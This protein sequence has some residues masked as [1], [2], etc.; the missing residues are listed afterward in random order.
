[1]PLVSVV[2]SVYNDGHYV[3]DAIESI[4][5]Q[6]FADFELLIVDDGCTDD[7][8]AIIATYHDA[9]IR[10]IINE[11]NI[12]L[13]PSLNR[14]IRLSGAKY[15][16]RQDADD[17]SLPDRLS[18]EVDYLENHPEVALLGSA[19]MVISHD[20]QPRG[21]WPALAE[22]LDL[23]WSLLFV[24]P[25]IHSSVMVRRSV[26]E[27]AGYYTE[28]P[29]IARAFVEDYELWSR[30]NRIA[31]SANLPQPLLKFRQNPTS[32]SV[33]T[34]VDHLRQRDRIAQENLCWVW[35]VPE[36]EEATWRRLGRFLRHP[37]GENLDLDRTEVRPTLSLLESLHAAFCK[38]Y[39]IPPKLADLHRRRTY[40]QWTRHAWALALRQNGRRDLG[41]RLA[42]LA[43][44]TKLLGSAGL[45]CAA[46]S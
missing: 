41:C 18:R 15:I 16:A 35:G 25:F 12:G 34:H 42:L 46:T 1:M 28:R 45:R 43:T 36:L 5:A 9:R 20:G 13:A 14:A 30:I 40:W 23:K 3:K 4:L 37:P 32:A 10:L 38:K 2:M 19:A 27:Q 26:V 33:R 7:T 24:N 44:G 29:D 21:D 22:D 17:I 11:R 39:E 6:T 31:R 8:R